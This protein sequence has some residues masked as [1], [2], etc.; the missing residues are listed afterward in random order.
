MKYN[1]LREATLLKRYKRFLADVE[2]PTGEQLTVHCPNT[3]KMTGCAQPGS[4]VWLSHSNNPKRK[5]AY[6]WELVETS[7][8][9]LA[10]VHSAKAN[11]LVIEALQTGVIKELNGF[12][13]LKKECRFGE[14]NS[15]ADVW[16]RFDDQS[17]YIEVKSVTLDMGAGVGM[18]P[19]AVSARGAKHLRELIRVRQ[20]GSRAV[21]L[22]CVQHEA[23]NRVRSAE[24][25][26]IVYAQTLKEALAAGVEV[27]AY[28]VE[29]SAEK[30]S[31]V[32]SVPFSL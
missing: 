16:L 32:K 14:E 12:D 25:I 22:F 1:N 10:S 7:P 30:I 5:Y 26:D 28:K 2:F 24:H 6:T 21:L 20:Q 8:G 19:D 11:N 18:F 4:R 31:L 29:V 13:E 15:R 27:L 17:C 23:I 3:G 9:V